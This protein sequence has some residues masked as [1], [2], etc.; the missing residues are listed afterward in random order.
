MAIKIDYQNDQIYNWRACAK[1]ALSDYVNAIVDYTKAIKLST[2]EGVY[3]YS[4]G[5]AK[6]QANQIESA[7]IDFKKATKLG[8]IFPKE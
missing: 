2:E 3:Y 8:Y 5:L 6:R 1:Y 7:K 4:R